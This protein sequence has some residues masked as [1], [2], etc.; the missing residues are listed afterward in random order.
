MN[1]LPIHWLTEMPFDFEF[2]YYTLLAQVKRQKS[3]IKNFILLSTLDEIESSLSTLYDI[4]YAR[5]GIESD[6][7]NVVGIDIDT[8][9]IEFDYPE[10]NK[11][12][13][14]MYDLCDTA[15]E[16]YETLHKDLRSKW[17]HASDLIRISNI[18]L[19]SIK[20]KGFIYVKNGDELIT[21]KTFIP[22]QY[23]NTWRHVMVDFVSVEPYDL[24]KLTTFIKNQEIGLKHYRCDLVRDMPINECVIPILKSVLYKNLI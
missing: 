21:Y 1:E 8:M 17:R 23:K 15:I 13:E 7:L 11:D 22:I 6:S 19:N 18:G 14:S 9:E 12:I 16:L 10:L 24:K 2:K 4:K 20:N 5:D 3:N